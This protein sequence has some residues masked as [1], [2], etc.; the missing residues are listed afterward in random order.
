MSFLLRFGDVYIEE[1]RTEF[2]EY[3]NREPRDWT[4]HAKEMGLNRATIQ[5][6]FEGKKTP[7]LTNLG[8]IEKFLKKINKK[9]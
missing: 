8:K 9:K 2:R 3:I 6:F 1:L 7:T 4:E 5:F